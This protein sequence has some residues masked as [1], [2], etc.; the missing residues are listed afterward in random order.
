M[1]NLEIFVLQTL[2]FG[3]AYAVFG[4]R[5]EL[6][7]LVGVVT[8]AIYQTSP[9]FV[10]IEG[11]V[12][13]VY[14]SDL[15]LPVLVLKALRDPSVR[16][17]ATRDPIWIGCLL[18][19]LVIP[20]TAGLLNFMFDE[21][22]IDSRAFMGTS[23]WFYRNIN[24]LFLIL[25]GLSLRLDVDQIAAFFRLNIVMATVLACFGAI[26]YWFGINMAVFDRLL[27]VNDDNAAIF[28][29]QTR[30]G[31]GFLGLFR[32][33]V[34]Q[35]CAIMALMLIGVIGMR[36]TGSKLLKLFVS[37]AMASFVLFSLS[38][39]G[40]LGLSLGLIALSLM[41]RDASQRLW[42]ILGIIGGILSFFVLDEVFVERIQGIVIAADN[43]SLTR[44]TAWELIYRYLIENPLALMIGI[45]P[46][47]E[48]GTFLI[49]GTYGT[50]N[51]FIESVLRM[52]LLGLGILLWLIWNM[53]RRYLQLRNSNNATLRIL[54][55][56]ML[57]I[58]A[59]NLIVSVTQ[60]HLLHSYATYTLGAFIYWFYGVTLSV[61]VR[62][63]SYLE[64][65]R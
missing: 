55:S 48:Y 9:M 25:Y 39:G 65:M 54:G 40:G 4:R 19:L 15:L 8:L 12:S 16:R 58:L 41:V 22:S 61:G 53:G 51:E 60:A 49:A 38:R 13:A 26:N 46:T 5:N 32:G 2:A 1:S 45:G 30:I 14:V 11:A 3:F 6:P 50:H 10:V 44:L 7:S 59:A 23:I 42:P 17:V 27:A 57:A 62:Q 36:G 35:W 64:K 34:G 43:S 28:L 56:T 18:F 24:F 47:N 63:N 20:A 37:V 31:Y 21:S 52:G 29:D 33:S